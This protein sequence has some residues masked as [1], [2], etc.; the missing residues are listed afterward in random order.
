[1]KTFVKA[2][3]MLALAVSAAGCAMGANDSP[4]DT[5]AVQNRY[6]V[7]ANAV[8]ASAGLPYLADTI[9]V[10]VSL[11]VFNIKSNSSITVSPAGFL[12][13]FGKLQANPAPDIIAAA[14]DTGDLTKWGDVVVSINGNEAV[15]TRSYMV[16]ATVN[17]EMITGTGAST[18]Y[19]TKVGGE[20]KL[21][22]L[23][24]SAVWRY[25]H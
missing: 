2:A 23:K 20:W 21:Y 25:V 8:N 12:H 22:K 17:T 1:M 5:R 4:A 14:V 19:W 11:D 9:N 3:L 6:A 7:V 24:H 18:A 16:T 13:W 10:E 15:A